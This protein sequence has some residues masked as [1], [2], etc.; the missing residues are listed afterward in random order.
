[1]EEYLNW[2]GESISNFFSNAGEVIGAVKDYFRLVL[3]WIGNIQ[4]IV[5]SVLAFFPSSIVFHIMTI[6]S[7]VVALVV[8]KA[9]LQMYSTF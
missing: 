1:M 3:D 6:V 4:N 9:V 7:L 2:L 5:S 8:V